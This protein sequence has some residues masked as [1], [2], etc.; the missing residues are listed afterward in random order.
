MKLS[1]VIPVYNE[2]DTLP[3]VLLCVFQAL[4]E[5]PKEVI[6]VDDG[7]TDGTETW[8]KKNFE[9]ACRRSIFVAL[10]DGHL[11]P[12]SK[13]LSNVETSLRIFLKSSN[14]GKGAALRTGF[15]MAQ[16]DVLVVQDAD[17]EYDPQDWSK[18]WELIAKG[19]ADV[20]FSSRFSGEPHRVLYFYHY[21]GN[22][23]ITKLTDWFCDI[24]LGDIE[25]G[26]KMF[27]R[28]VLDGLHLNC[29]D[30]G[31]EVEFTVKV[32][33]AKRWRIYEKGVS[34]YGRTYAEGKKI[35]WKD[36]IKALWYIVKYRFFDRG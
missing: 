21:L 33:K 7:S 14:E 17:L 8:L 2:R 29:N 22:K 1:V 10:E 18:M 4:P 25:S 27:R 35:G 9:E 28:E 20:V 34:Y 30:F 12:T 3:Q 32:A 23:I 16:G 15:Q 19:R 26:T 11:R 24:N 31:F 6:V 5:V 36:G 13:C